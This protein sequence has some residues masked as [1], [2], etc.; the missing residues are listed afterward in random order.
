M[1]EVQGEQEAHCFGFWRACETTRE[2]GPAEPLRGVQA[3]QSA[4]SKLTA[5]ALSAEADSQEGSHLVG[6]LQW[7]KFYFFSF[8]RRENQ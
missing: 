2:V 6:I 1:L 3:A 4:V 5:R 8:Q 7:G